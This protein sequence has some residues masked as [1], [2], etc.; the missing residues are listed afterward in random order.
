MYKDAGMTMF[1][2]QSVLKI[3]GEKGSMRDAN[4]A[5]VEEF[6]ADRAADFE[7]VKVEIDKLVAIGMDKTILY[8][9][10]LSWLGL[11]EPD[12]NATPNLTDGERL[13]EGLIGEAEDQ[14]ATVEELDAQVEQL[15]SL[16]ADYPGVGGVSLADEP[17][18]VWHKSYGDLYNSIKRVCAKNNWDL[19]ISFNLNPLNLTEL[20]YEQYYPYVEGTAGANEVTGKVTFEDIVCPMGAS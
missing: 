7:R 9:E 11:N 19:Y 3:R 14:Y 20:V 10:N 2:P 4:A 16:Y 15:L 6:Y 5:A 17:K 13:A 8:D 18:N 1:Y 12:R